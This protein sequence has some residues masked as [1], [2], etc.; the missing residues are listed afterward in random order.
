[1]TVAQVFSSIHLTGQ[2]RSEKNE[3]KSILNIK[4]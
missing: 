1:M 4:S 3:A 2:T